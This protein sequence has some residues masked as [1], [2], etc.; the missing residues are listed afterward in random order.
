MNFLVIA[1]LCLLSVVVLCALSAIAGRRRT[2]RTHRI[3]FYAGLVG[4]F[5]VA[6]WLI[7]LRAVSLQVPYLRLA[8]PSGALFAVSTV[9]MFSA[10]VLSIL[11]L[12]SFRLGPK[13]AA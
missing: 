3:A 2:T 12:L 11:A 7:A 9:V 8:T 4:L 13:S 6:T 1:L 10:S 5:S